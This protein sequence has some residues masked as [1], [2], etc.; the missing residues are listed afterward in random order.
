MP[1][2]LLETLVAFFKALADETR[3]KLLG[4]LAQRECS[5]EEIAVTLGVKEPTVSHHLAKLKELNLVLMR[6]E[7]NSRLYRLNAEGLRGLSE[8]L[9]T[10]EAIAEAAA[11]DLE[12]DRFER[13][14]MQTFVQN[15]RLTAIPTQRKKRDVLL[16]WLA[17][18]FEPGVRYTEPEVNETL[19]RF[20]ADFA[21]LRREFIMTGL[22]KREDGRVGAQSVYWRS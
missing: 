14:V 11:P 7:G 9:L 13:K 5:V 1:P 3:L 2:E 12:G 16:R 6:A 15:G 8:D 22:M 20:H 10:P 18:H 17:S 19:K 21:T 4:L